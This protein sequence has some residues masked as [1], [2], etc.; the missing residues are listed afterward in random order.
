M[1]FS[2]GKT[3]PRFSTGGFVKVQAVAK[4]NLFLDVLGK[5]SDG[6]HDLFSIMQAVDLCDELLISL[7]SEK[8]SET[9]VCHLVCDLEGLP[10]DG[11]NLVVK[12]GNLLIREYGIMQN[13]NIEL[14][15]R[16]PV[17]AGLAG[18]SSDCAAALLGIN[19]LL[20]LSIP[21]DKLLEIGKSLGADVP[22]CLYANAG[23][24]KGLLRTA[25]TEGIGEKIS[26]L[27]PHPPCFIVI[28]CPN[29]HV[30]TAEIFSH[31]KLSHASTEKR[32][33]IVNAFNNSDIT[34]IAKNLYNTFTP[35][36]SHLHP[37]ISELIANFL[38]AGAMG[39]EMSGTG[40]SVFAYFDSEK[41]A[42]KALNILR[43]Q[44]ILSAPLVS[45]SPLLGG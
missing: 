11:E 27:P 5:R 6:Y 40:S 31:Y 39:A 37:E 25:I 13:L 26:P 3:N 29:I 22:F 17:G 38:D 7:G 9:A 24:R 42:E 20:D 14:T 32:Q 36:T 18:G 43:H 12:A 10:A 4:I 34:K 33:N 15:K 16:I 35:I 44:L 21:F 41:L 28:A 8:T 1:P 30:S 19:E 45:Q 2:V 23:Y